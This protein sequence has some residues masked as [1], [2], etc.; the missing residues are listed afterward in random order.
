MLEHV[1][2]QEQGSVGGKVPASEV[3]SLFFSFI[4]FVGVLVPRFWLFSSRRKVIEIRCFNK[5]MLG[6]SF[7]DQKQQGGGHQ[8][9]LHDGEWSDPNVVKCYDN[10]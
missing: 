2:E 5:E 10:N 7:Y 3:L 8:K 6:V 9:C 4:N 1:Y